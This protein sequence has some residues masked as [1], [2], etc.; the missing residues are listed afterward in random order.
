MEEGEFVRPDTGYFVDEMEA[1]QA[2]VVH[3]PEVEKVGSG[4]GDNE[5]LRGEGR[6]NDL[7][8]DSNLEL[9]AFDNGDIGVA[10][11]V[12]PTPSHLFLVTDNAKLVSSGDGPCNKLGLNQT[13]LSRKRPRCLRRSQSSESRHRPAGLK[14]VII[15]CELPDLNA[16]LRNLAPESP[17]FLHP[18]EASNEVIPDTYPASDLGIGLEP[19]DINNEVELTVQIGE[20]IGVDLIGSEGLVAKAIEGRIKLWFKAEHAKRFGKINVLK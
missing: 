13:P 6:P 10:K 1:E 7:H 16:P 19:G 20:L 5:E 8:G 18:M 4:P 17:T 3:T 14:P 12:G 9:N 11:D 2:P 15:S